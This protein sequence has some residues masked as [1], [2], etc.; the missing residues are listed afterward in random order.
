MKPH[1]PYGRQWIDDSDI[2]AVTRCLR[3]DFLTQGPLIREFEEAL[4]ARLNAPYA[5]MVSN[6]TAALHLIG[7]ALGW[8]PGDHVI[9]SPITFVASA[10]AVLYTG[11]TPEFVDIHPETYTLDPICLEKKVKELLQ[12]G[13]KVKAVVAV[14]YAGHPADWKT[15]RAL[16][17]QYQFQLVDDACHALGA[18][19]GAIEIGSAHFADAAA[20]SFHPVKHLTTGE[21]GAILTQSPALDEKVKLL[22]T[23]GITKNPDHMSASEGPWYYEMQE[24]G[25]NYRITDFQCALG[26]NQLKKLDH[27]L[28]RRNQIADFYDQAFAQD[29]R[30][31]LPKVLANTFH[32]YHLYP[33]QIQWSQTK[34]DKIAFFE[35]LEA[36]GIFVQVHYIPV[37]FQPYYQKNFLFKRGLCPEAELFYQ[38]EVS[39]P[40]HSLLNQE[41]LEYI[42]KEIR[43]SLS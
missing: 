30:L 25:F 29:P 40:M 21:G 43:N 26:L 19:M 8:Q 24:L 7:L 20:L 31:I 42:V 17:D 14:D 18:R 39:L 41:D 4:S 38:R 5:T 2:E 1:Y 6:G 16:A 23:H 34:T 12:S 13:K 3:S 36:K 35:R 32:A 37:Y 27:S 33:L 10:N 22:R 15:L 28:A 11:A 9:T